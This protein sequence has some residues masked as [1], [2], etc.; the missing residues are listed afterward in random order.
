MDVLKLGMP[1]RPENPKA[2][3]EG[4]LADINLFTEE[5]AAI[6]YWAR[7]WN[8]RLGEGIIDWKALSEALEAQGV[9]AYI[10]EREYFSYEGG[11]D[12]VTCSRQDYEYLKRL[13][14]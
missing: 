9:E 7:H 5:Q 13:L 8:G 4:V 11:G 10:C 14:G 2:A 3:K 6:M 1:I 12:A